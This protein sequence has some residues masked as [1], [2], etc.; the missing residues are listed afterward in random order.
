[1]LMTATGW[2]QDD[3]RRLTKPF[4]PQ[5]LSTWIAEFPVSAPDVGTGLP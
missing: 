1:M 3:D 2:G 5:Q 4:D